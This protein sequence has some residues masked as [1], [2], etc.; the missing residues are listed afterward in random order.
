MS[1]SD[2]VAYFCALPHP[3]L[4]ELTTLRQGGQAL[5]VSFLETRV[6]LPS[7]PLFVI[8][9][10]LLLHLISVSLFS[11]HWLVRWCRGAH[12]TRCQKSPPQQS[13]KTSNIN[14]QKIICLGKSGQYVLLTMKRAQVMLLDATQFLIENEM[15]ESR[16]E[17][18]V[19]K[20]SSPTSSQTSNLYNM[21]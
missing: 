1:V 7:H 14:L 13:H 11:F 8:V 6:L 12:A 18:L 4:E 21:H 16:E 19:E 2:G 20:R 15:Q 17:Y 9:G 10:K 3:T 5:E